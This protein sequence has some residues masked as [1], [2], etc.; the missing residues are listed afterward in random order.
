MA[1]PQQGVNNHMQVYVSYSADIID[2][3]DVTGDI[4]TKLSKRYRGQRNGGIMYVF[5]PYTST[6]WFSIPKKKVPLFKRI[7]KRYSAKIGKKI[8]ICI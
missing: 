8:T 2:G 3:H 7:V 1:Q 5:A 4:L 6:A